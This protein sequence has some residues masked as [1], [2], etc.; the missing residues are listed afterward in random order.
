MWP[1]RGLLH[2]ELALPLLLA[3]L[4]GSPVPPGQSPSPSAPHSMP[5]VVWPCPHPKPHLPTFLFSHLLSDHSECWFPQ[6][7]VTS[8]PSHFCMG[9]FLPL[10]CPA[11]IPTSVPG[12]LF[13]ILQVSDETPPPL[14]GPSLFPDW[15]SDSS[16]SHSC[17]PLSHFPAALAWLG[18]DSLFGDPLPWIVSGMRAEPIC[19]AHFCFSNTHLGSGSY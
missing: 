5:H 12:Q 17:G 8:F 10:E 6:C 2:P 11:H 4:H 16:D 9:R 15:T 7:T 13:H 18:G 14:E 19:H 1:Q 3:A